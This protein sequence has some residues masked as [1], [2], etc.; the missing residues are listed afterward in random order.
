MVSWSGALNDQQIRDVSAY[1]LKFKPA[2][3]APAKDA[4]KPAAKK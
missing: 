4:T 3:A 1:V 2:Q